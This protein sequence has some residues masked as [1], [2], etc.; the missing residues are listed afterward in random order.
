MPEAIYEMRVYNASGVLE[1][2]A[3]DIDFAY[4]NQ[5]NAAGFLRF[6]VDENHRLA[7]NLGR[8]WRVDVHRSRA[9]DAGESNAIARYED[10]SGFVR[11][12][13]RRADSD[14][15]TQ[16]TYL[17]PGKRSLLGRA[18]VGYK[19]GVDL[20]SEFTGDK[21]ETILKNLVKYNLTSSGTTGDGRVR[22][23]SE[24]RISVQA[25]GAGGNTLDYACAYRNL[26]EVLPDVAAVGGGDYDL[27]R[28]GANA[29]EFRW[30]AGQ[31][32]TDRSAT[33]TFSLA[34]GNMAN[35]VLNRNWIDEKTVAIVG[36][37]GEESS[38][39]LVVRTGTNY[40]A[41]VN[42]VEMF[43]DARDLTTTNGLNARGDVYLDG[44]EAKDTLTFD[45]IQ[46]PGSLYGLHYFLGD[47]VTA[48][49]QGITATKQI[50]GVSVEFSSQGQESIKVEMKNV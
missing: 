49:Y 17:C 13:E 15:N 12:E 2:V 40:D 44:A 3:D 23:A 37:Q 1:Y 9:A 29:W 20:R 14:G 21:A 45:V 41:A 46:T 31:L 6:A 39:T 19:A 43:V 24:T 26:L 32:G 22:N 34:Y 18:I 28:T 50:V 48:Y 16:I 35:P 33:V 27:V 25:D 47:K 10:F 42:G 8:D 5:V 30:Y 38:R 11:N 36:G 4:T 7:G